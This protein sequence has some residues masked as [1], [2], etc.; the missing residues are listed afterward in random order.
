MP[1]GR[2]AQSS[3]G[4]CRLLSSALTT[5][6]QPESL[7]F[8]TRSNMSEAPL[9]MYTSPLTSNSRVLG[10]EAQLLFDDFAKGADG[11]VIELACDVDQGT[12]SL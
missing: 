7:N 10:P 9:S 11:I 4:V 8:W 1:V 12:P 3:R 2:Q 6:T 5:P